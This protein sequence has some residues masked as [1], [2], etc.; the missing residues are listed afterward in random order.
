MADNSLITLLNRSR[1]L[2]EEA[3]ALR[4]RSDALQKQ[5][6][7]IEREAAVAAEEKR[8]LNGHVDSVALP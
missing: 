2:A 5:I 3:R 4:R 8:K 7:E 1:R 6:V